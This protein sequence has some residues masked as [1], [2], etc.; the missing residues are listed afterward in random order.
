MCNIDVCIE[1][2]RLVV[3]DSGKVIAV[4]GTGIEQLKE[5]GASHVINYRDGGW[6]EAARIA[7]K[8]SINFV[9]D[10][11]GGSMLEG[12]LRIGKDEGSVLT[13][14]SPAPKWEQV[15][16]WKEALERRV[17]AW[18]FIVEENGSQ[19][20]EIAQLVQSGALKV[21]VSEIVQGLTENGVRE[22]WSRAV[23]GG[24][25]GSVVINVAP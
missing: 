2:A 7:G 16:G 10:C 13:V 1:I 5:L 11:I 18:F 4:G 8:G 20:A 23:K 17:Q 21:G 15:D 25:A 14:G 12:S 6:E 9:L 24:M 22:A 3:G 19:V